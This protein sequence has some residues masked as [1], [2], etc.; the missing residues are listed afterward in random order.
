MLYRFIIQS[1]LKSLYLEFVV[2]TF[3]DMNWVTDKKLYFLDKKEWSGKHSV[4][5][6]PFCLI[7][8]SF[9]DCQLSHSLQLN[10]SKIEILITGNFRCFF[11]F[12]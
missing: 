7:I 10:L 1:M 5:S 8:I 9:K 3:K 6:N 12:F 4:F 2:V 11:F